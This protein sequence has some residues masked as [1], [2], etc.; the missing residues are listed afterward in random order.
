MVEFGLV[1][2]IGEPAGSDDIVCP[3]GS[4]G[5][6]LEFVTATEGLLRL[7]GFS[8]CDCG[9]TIEGLVEELD[10]IGEWETEEAWYVLANEEFTDV[11]NSLTKAGYSDVDIVVFP[12]LF[13]VF[14]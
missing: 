3:D 2:L 1:V 7:G 4:F 6:W 5:S 10:L 11:N 9:V 8:C 13:I 14:I 12:N